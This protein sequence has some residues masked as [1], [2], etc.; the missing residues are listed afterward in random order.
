MVLKVA[1]LEASEVEFS[2]QEGL[3]EAQILT[4][5]EIEAAVG[6]ATIVDPTADTLQIPQASGGVFEDG[7]EFQVAPVGGLPAGVWGAGRRG[8]GR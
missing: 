2:P 5:K 4:F 3:E 1:I 8:C 6:A 7:E